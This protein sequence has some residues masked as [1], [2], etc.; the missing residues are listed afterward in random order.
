MYE[1]RPWFRLSAL[2]VGYAPADN[3]TIAVAVMVEHGGFGA[4]TAGPIARKIFDAWLLGTMPEGVP[5]P[6]GPL[7]PDAQPDVEPAPEPATPAVAA[8]APGAVH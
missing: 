3:P 6:T 8:A 4:S 7:D 1:T 2:F 5:M